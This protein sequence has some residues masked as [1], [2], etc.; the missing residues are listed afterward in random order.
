MLVVRL[1]DTGIKMLYFDFIGK[2][3]HLNK[4]YTIYSWMLKNFSMQYLN[5]ND[6]LIKIHFWFKY[7]SNFWTKHENICRHFIEL[8]HYYIHLL[9]VKGFLSLKIIWFYDYFI[10]I[11]HFQISTLSL[12]IFWYEFKIILLNYII[13]TVYWTFK[14]HALSLTIFW[15]EFMIILLNYIII[16]LDFQI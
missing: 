8:Y 16:I 14:F 9:N 10:I 4:F 11:L 5:D 15:Y 6:W 12:T 3:S 2:Y 1:Y 7:F 13:I